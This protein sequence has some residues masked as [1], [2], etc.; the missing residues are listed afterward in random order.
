MFFVHHNHAVM[1][2]FAHTLDQYGYLCVMDTVH[3]QSFG[4]IHL[5]DG[6]AACDN[7]GLTQLVVQLFDAPRRAEWMIFQHPLHGK[8]ANRCIAQA[9]G[10][11]LRQV[12]NGHIRLPHAMRL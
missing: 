7:K 4:Q 8:P 3:R 2:G 9:L 1:N 6:V 5:G 11:H 10:K 12:A